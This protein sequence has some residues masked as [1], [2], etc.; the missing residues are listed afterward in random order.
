[1]HIVCT[2]PINKFKYLINK[3][4]ELLPVQ[5]QIIL[6]NEGSFTRTLKYLTSQIIKVKTSQ[7]EQNIKTNTIRKIRC[8][9]LETSIYTK[10]LFARSLWYL[11]YKN[12]QL[13]NIKSQ[14]PIGQSFIEHQIDIHKKIHEIHY[15]YCEE[16]ER[17]LK[18]KEPLWGRKY[19]L[20]YK[21]KSYLTIQEIFSQKITIFFSL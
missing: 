14:L 7:K 16:L 2:I 21:D 12:R 18:S 17:T 10:L 19:T 15:G 3:V 5:L 4:P 6:I 8:V 13:Q 20:Y 9:W 11:I 1:M